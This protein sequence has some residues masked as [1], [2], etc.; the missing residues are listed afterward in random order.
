M[1]CIQY[2]KDSYSEPLF[3]NP[4]IRLTIFVLVMNILPYICVLSIRIYKRLKKK[5]NGIN[6]ISFHS[7][8]AFVRFST[9]FCLGIRVHGHKSVSNI[10]QM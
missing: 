6:I 7:A 2:P 4:T 3:D 9:L 10:F 5:V 8:K 1:P